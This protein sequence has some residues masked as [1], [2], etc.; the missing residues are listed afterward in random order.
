M[1]ERVRVKAREPLS[2]PPTAYPPPLLDGAG[3]R[4]ERERE[5]EEEREEERKEER[6]EEWR[7]SERSATQTA[8]ELSAILFYLSRLPLDRIHRFLTLRAFSV[9]PHGR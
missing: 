9:A 3:E 2:F 5:R 6:K 7:E 8:K 1:K 4:K